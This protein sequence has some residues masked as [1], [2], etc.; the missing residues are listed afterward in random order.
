MILVIGLGRARAILAH[1]GRCP[2][3]ARRTP[4]RWTALAG[5]GAADDVPIARR[6]SVRG[7]PED[8][9]E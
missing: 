5:I 8:R 3:V 9:F 2:S 1:S 6:L 4:E 7:E